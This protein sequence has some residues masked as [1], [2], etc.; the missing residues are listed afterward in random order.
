MRVSQKFKREIEAEIKRLSESS[1]VLSLVDSAIA[2]LNT[3]MEEM[4]T[5][6]GRLSRDSS[7]E[8]RRAQ[9]VIGNAVS[10]TRKAHQA[11]KGIRPQVYKLR[12]L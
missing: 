5:A 2:H 1:E 11:L 3:A 6:E 10:P 12:D 9:A 7:K 8:G 4:L